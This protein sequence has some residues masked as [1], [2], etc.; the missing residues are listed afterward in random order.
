M[1]VGSAGIDAQVRH[2]NTAQTVARN[3][4]LDRFF[5]DAL[6]MCAVKDLFCRA[7]LD[8]ARVA[9]V[10]VVFLVFTLGPG[11]LD[12]VSID[13]DDIIPHVHVGREGRLGFAAQDRCGQRGEAA[14]NNAFSVDQD[15]LLHDIRRRCGEGFHIRT[16]CEKGGRAAVVEDEGLSLKGAAWSRAR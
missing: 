7:H 11:H 14:Q 2:L 3:H 5:H 10:P 13:D 16:Q 8:A 4:P 15:P 6:R 12:F 1:R 9:G